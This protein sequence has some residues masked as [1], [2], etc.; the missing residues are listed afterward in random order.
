MFFGCRLEMS[1]STFSHIKYRVSNP[2]FCVLCIVIY[3]CVSVILCNDSQLQTERHSQDFKP[4]HLKVH[5][6]GGFVAFLISVPAKP[7]SN[8]CSNVNLTTP[9][10]NAICKYS[11]IGLLYAH[12][13]K[14]YIFKT[15]NL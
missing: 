3:F 4:L 13:T 6:D 10:R 14:H 9:F 7:L 12:S 8:S 15:L 5:S 11:V 1:S 2:V